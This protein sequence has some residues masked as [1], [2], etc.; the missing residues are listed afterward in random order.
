[1]L[2]L[3]RKLRESIKIGSDVT[4]TVLRVKGQTVRIGI[5]APRDKRVIRGELPQF[6]EA[7]IDLSDG[8]EKEPRHKHESQLG[9]N[10]T[11]RPRVPEAPAVEVAD[12]YSSS[13]AVVADEPAPASGPLFRLLHS[14][15]SP[16]RPR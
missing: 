14:R 4:I 9:K 15:T 11:E 10:A 12:P 5:E 3:T 13:R 16:V 2:V 8:G 1:M 7:E 6:M